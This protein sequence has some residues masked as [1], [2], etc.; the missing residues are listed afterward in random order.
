ML[1][2]VLPS[3]TFAMSYGLSFLSIAATIPHAI[4]YFA[5][6]IMVHFKRSL[7]E[8]PDIH[9]KLMKAYPRSASICPLMF[10]AV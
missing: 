5:K 7:R 9:A 4:L 1:I 10:S 2:I 8:P 3:I 6:P